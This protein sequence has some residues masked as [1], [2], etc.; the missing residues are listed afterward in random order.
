[1]TDKTSLPTLQWLVDREAWLKKERG[2]G[3]DWD[4]LSARL[5]ECAYIREKLQRA[6]VLG[7][8]AITAIARKHFTTLNEVYL[9]NK[10][11]RAA[12]AQKAAPLTEPAAP[13]RTCSYH[14]FASTCINCGESEAAAPATPADPLIERLR[15][16]SERA[17]PG[18][19]E[20][21]DSP[22]APFDGEFRVL[23]PFFPTHVKG[24]SFDDR[25]WIAFLKNYDNAA[26]IAAMRTGLPTLLEHAHN[27]RDTLRAT[28]CTLQDR[29]E[30]AESRLSTARDEGFAEARAAAAKVCDECRVL[31]DA[32]SMEGAAKDAALQ[33]ATQ[34]RALTPSLTALEAFKAVG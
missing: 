31:I 4:H 34:I 27:A 8:E 24:Q 22:S 7:E 16:L 12:L 14:I 15:E 6:P 5:D 33:L 28:N 9:C 13:K 10:A 11:I 19:W 2:N 1:M 26:L 30:L 23:G 29:A 18:P 25:A 3:G 17:T 20:C 21:K 32:E